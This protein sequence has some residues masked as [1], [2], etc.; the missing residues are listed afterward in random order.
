MLLH[1]STSF[2]SSS[3]MSR[4]NYFLKKEVCG[5]SCD[6]Y[7]EVVVIVTVSGLKLMGCC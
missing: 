6:D 1:E 3:G 4:Y 7:A 5:D 2:H